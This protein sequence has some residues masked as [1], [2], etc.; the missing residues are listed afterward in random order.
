MALQKDI[1]LMG[2]VQLTAHTLPSSEEIDYRA[3]SESDL[4]WLVNAHLAYGAQGLWYYNWRIRD[5]HFSEG[6][7]EGESGESTELYPMVQKVNAGVSALG[8][9]LMKLKSK[10]VVHTDEVVPMG[11]TRYAPGTITGLRDFVGHSCIVSEFYNQDDPADPAVYLMIVSKLHAAER[12]SAELMQSY[13]F[14]IYPDYPGP[15]KS[16]Y[17]GLNELFIVCPLP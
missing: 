14:D 16:R 1:G 2:F 8:D 6:L 12:A 4:N 9:V 5:E 11:T 10:R 3:P 13:S 7:V 17:N 15:H